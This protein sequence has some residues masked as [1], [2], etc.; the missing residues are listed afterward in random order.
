MR[1]LLLFTSSLIAASAVF[2]LRTTPAFKAQVLTEKESCESYLSH[3]IP[4]FKLIRKSRPYS[5]PGLQLF[6]S[7]SPSNVDRD[8]LIAMSCR[9]GKQYAHEHALSVWILDSDRA[10]KRYNPQGEG[11]DRVTA[12]SFR[13]LY[14]FDRENGTGSQ[15]LEWRPDP[16]NKARLIHIDL[17]KA[18]Q[19]D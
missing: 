2:A 16:D 12:S 6:V 19:A 7:I 15:S 5:K 3:E 14:G 8:K 18:P 10:A 4:R 9:L 13:A 11:N 1:S 17:G